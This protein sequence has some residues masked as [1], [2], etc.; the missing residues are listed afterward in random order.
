MKVSENAIALIKKFEG[1]SP[2]LY[3]CPAGKLTIGYG[4]VVFADAE[5][6]KYRNGISEFEASTLLL[7]DCQTVENF[8]NK[9]IKLDYQSEFDALVSLLFNIGIDRFKRSKAFDLLKK[10]D[11]G[12]AAFQMFDKVEG[13]VKVNDKPIAGLVKRRDEEYK[14]WFKDYARFGT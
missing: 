9:N 2:R 4:H 5:I 10:K 12:A 1:F 6:F 13:F 3:T 8:I 14:L 7:Q 11:Y